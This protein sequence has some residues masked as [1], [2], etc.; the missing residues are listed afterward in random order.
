MAQL[1]ADYPGIRFVYV[2][3]HLD[4]TGAAENLNLRN[5]QI[6]DYC[7]A[8]NKTLFDFADIESYDPNGISNYMVLKADD[9]CDYDSNGDGSS[10]AN[11][12]AN[13]VAANP[14]QELTILASTICSDCCA[15]SQPLNCALKGRA[16]WWL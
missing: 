13:W 12:A 11:W 6:R 15:H 9:H 2:T 4:G 8:N 16:A 14:S 1:E 5:Q 3:G 10:D 7:A